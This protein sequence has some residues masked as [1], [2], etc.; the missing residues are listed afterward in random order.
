MAIRIFDE[1]TTVSRRALLRGAAGG[2]LALSGVLAL[3][4][5]SRANTRPGLPSGVQSGDIGADRGV[6]WARADRP[7]RA[8]FEWSTTESFSDLHRLPALDALPDTGHAVK[9]LA[10]N[11]PSDQ[12]IFWRVSMTDLSDL[13]A[14]SES[15]IGH[16]RTAPTERQSTH[17]TVNIDSFGKPAVSRKP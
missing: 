13:N 15:A 5:F 4:G 6:L 10:E 3:P 14:V 16:F 7:S 12:D 17:H 1:T 11:L 9:I 8:H 2:T